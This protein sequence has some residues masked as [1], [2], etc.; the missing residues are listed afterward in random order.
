MQKVNQCLA[1]QSSN[2]KSFI[3]TPAQMHPSDQ[4]F[5]FDQCTDCGLVFLNPRVTLEELEDYYTDFYLPYRGANA[6]GKYHK[7]V[8]SS[9]LKL[10]QKRYELVNQHVKSSN[11]SVLLD[12]GCGKNA[13]AKTCAVTYGYRTTEQ[14]E[15][16]NPDFII[17]ELSEIKNIIFS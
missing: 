2:F 8:E 12:I 13:G 15:K 14:L 5:N 11:K 4:M 6:W 9:Q 7:Q 16:E 3:Q 10:D 1:C 17:N